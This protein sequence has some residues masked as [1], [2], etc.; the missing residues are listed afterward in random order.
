VVGTHPPMREWITTMAAARKPKTWTEVHDAVD[1]R[2]IELGWSRNDL[3][4]ATGTSH[5][6][7]SHMKNQGRAI[8][9][10]DKVTALCSALGWT[11]DSVDLI[12]AGGEPQLADESDNQTTEQML[13]VLQQMV[14]DNRRLRAELDA[15]ARRLDELERRRSQ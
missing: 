2:R 10:P 12:L 5:A 3:F 11:A 14:D 1:A 13:E 9:R 8:G 4:N 15:L 7:F 6:T